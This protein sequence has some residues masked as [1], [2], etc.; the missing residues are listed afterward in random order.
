MHF[1]SNQV[2]ESVLSIEDAIQAL[3]MAYASPVDSRNTPRRTIVDGDGAGFRVLPSAPPATRYFGAKLMGA[4]TTS[5]RFRGVGYVIV[6]FDREAGEI[7]ALVDGKFITGCRT[8][9]T[10]A[11]ALDR[12]AP[13]G[14]IRL[15][16]LGSGF[17]ASMHVRAFAAVRP[18]QEVIVFSPTPERRAAFATTMTDALG[19]PCHAAESADAAADLFRTSVDVVL[20]AARSRGEKPILFGDDLRP[21]VTVVSIGSTVPQQREIDASVVERCDLIVCDDVGEVVDETG[22]MIAAADAGLSFRDRCV[23]LHALMSGEAEELRKRAEIRMFKSV[24]S[25]LQDVVI[26]GLVLDRAIESG[27]AT[28]LPVAFAT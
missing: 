15:G 26:A 4:T 19:V 9:A 17:E 27:R 1:V 25:G 28:P 23:S 13:P 5:G 11:A 8:A 18:V 10:S 16:V 6:L 7:A 20:A 14:P 24:G 3:Q 21:G 22:D 2:A 12:L